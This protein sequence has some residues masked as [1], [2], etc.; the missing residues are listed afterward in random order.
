M[1]TLPSPLSFASTSAGASRSLRRQRRSISPR[2]IT[3]L[4]GTVLSIAAVL[5]PA[6]ARAEGTDELMPTVGGTGRLGLL[7]TEVF[8]DIRTPAVERICIEG[9]NSAGA[10]QTVTVSAPDGSMVVE[11]FTTDGNCVSLLGRAPGAYRI[12]GFSGSFSS[13][14]R[15]DISVCAGAAATCD[16]STGNAL[17]LDGRVWAR[18]WTFNSTAT[19][20][21]ERGT[22]ASVFAR[23]PIGAFGTGVVE[24]QLSGVHG[25][26]RWELLANG[27]GIGGVNPTRSTRQG[28]TVAADYRIYLSLPDPL[29]EPYGIPDPQLSNFA[30][31]ATAE[32]A[33]CGVI[34]AGR[35]A[36]QFTFSSNMPGQ[37]RLICD[38][39][40]DSTFDPSGADDFV[41]S[42]PAVIGANTILWNGRDGEGVAISAGSYQCIVELNAGE[43]HYVAEDIEVAYPGLRMFQVAPNLSRTALPMF[44]NDSDVVPAMPLAMP[45]GEFPAP[46]APLGGLASGSYTAAATVHSTA[47][48]GNARG[49]GT[50][51]DSG[52]VTG[53]TGDM[54][55]IDTW[56]GLDTVR[57]GTTL[58]I[59]VDA[60]ADC[61]GTGGTD[62]EELCITGTLPCG[63]DRDLDCNDGDECTAD[64]CSMGSCLTSAQ[65][66]GT[67]CT[68]GFC[69]GAAATP[70]CFA[71][72]SDDD[73]AADAI[74]M[75]GQC[76]GTD[77]DMDGLSNLTECPELLT[78]PANCRDTDRDG[79]VD[80][81]DPDDDDDSI[82]TRE[83]RPE[84][85]DQDTDADGSPNHLDDD[86]DNDTIPTRQEV[87]DGTAHGNDPDMDGLVSWLDTD[88]DG[89]DEDDATELRGDEDSDGVPDYLDPRTAMP[90]P[91]P[92]PMPM[93]MPMPMPEPTPNA[94]LGTAGG[95]CSASPLTTP[96]MLRIA[97]FLGIAALTLGRRKRR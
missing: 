80:Y 46:T 56:T 75:M 87:E 40:A 42:G 66:R 85:R 35:N 6:A 61:D 26:S 25:L 45:N 33:V 14:R 50:F 29:V 13:T 49:W 18:R 10:S 73:C 17:H 72:L 86:D 22:S 97:A 82:P 84:G 89:V 96:S 70:M 38:T 27:V 7:P 76:R 8:V 5:L 20:S 47:S 44:W 54:N 65:P 9:R 77:D 31:Q 52:S 11:N 60:G 68:G 41:L 83:E 63:C 91:M 57:S 19:Q 64:L 51:A 59:L 23:V 81:L 39:N 12:D 88:S 15:W 28:R 62:F 21:V 32:G 43:F 36:G 58:V 48:L 30:F 93:P 67:M 1:N 74:C 4:T 95:A 3:T 92:E 53:S 78:M 90:M 16:A 24:L 71:C 34:E 37:Y 55:L 79:M 2:G 94:T 69:D